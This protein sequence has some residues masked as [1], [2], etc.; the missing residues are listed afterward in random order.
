[1]H[2]SGFFRVPT[3]RYEYVVFVCIYLCVVENWRLVVGVELIMDS[4]FEQ[5]LLNIPA[6]EYLRS[7][8]GKAK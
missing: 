3:C 7:L 8:G 1:V 5:H 2:E 6:V 4:V